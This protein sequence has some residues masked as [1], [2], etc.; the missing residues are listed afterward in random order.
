MTGRWR[1]RA[2]D[3]AF[4]AQN[5]SG[6]GSPEASLSVR[7]DRRVWLVGAASL[8]ISVAIALRVLIPYG[9][10]PT[11]FVSFGDRSPVQDAYVRERLGEVTTRGV[12]G[13]D[14]KFFFVQANDPWLLDPQR[15][16]ALLDRPVYRSQRMMYPLIA[17]GFGLFPPHMIVWAMLAI[18]LVAM[19][20]GAALVASLASI[21]GRSPWL[22][23]LVP[24]NIGLIFELTIGGAGIL[25]YALC[26]AGLFALTKHHIWAASMLFGAAALSREAMVLF[27]AGL[28]CLSWLYQRQ[29]IWRIVAVPV[30]AVVLWH[31]YI[32][33]RLNGVSGMGV[34]WG[35]FAPPFYG[36]F[37][38]FEW[39]LRYPHLLINIGVIVILVMFVP[40]ALRSRSPM[41]WGALPF[42]ALVIILSENVWREAYDLTRAVAPVFTAIPFLVVISGSRERYSIQGVRSERG[43]SH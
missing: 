35:G 13:A 37:K 5:V 2:L 15:N 14:G 17:G 39:W 40:L 42:V 9:M 41:A 24:L 11:I 27:P 32:R 10:D 16:A 18:N 6:N 29:A 21:W 28:L 20:L 19:A 43:P 25:A 3:S 26:L 30:G 31:M 12:S 1:R 4:G 33:I 22:G 7:R 34:V 23:L 38:G 8:A 36:M